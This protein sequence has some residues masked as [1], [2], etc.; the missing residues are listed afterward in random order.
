[1]ALS[2]RKSAAS[3]EKNTWVP[4]EKNVS[5]ITE[6]KKSTP[7]EKIPFAVTVKKILADTEIKNSVFTT[8]KSSAPTDRK[9]SQSEG[10]Q[11]INYYD[12]SQSIVSHLSKEEFKSSDTKLSQKLSS[13]GSLQ[14]RNLSEFLKKS[15]TD[16]ESLYVERSVCHVKIT[17]FNLIKQLGSGGFGSVILAELKQDKNLYAIKFIEK[18]IVLERKYFRYVNSEKRVLQSVNFPFIISLKYF[19]V[20]SKFLYFVMPF[21]PGGDFHKFLTKHPLVEKEAKFYIGQLVLALEYLHNLDVIHRDLKPQNVIIDALGYLKLAD[22]GQCIRCY[23]R[24]KTWTMTGTPEYMAPEILIGRGYD[25]SVDWWSLGVT[26][27]E[28]C[29]GKRPFS[30]DNKRKLYTLILSVKYSFPKHFSRS[31]KKFV[32]HL[33]VGEPSKRMANNDKKASEV[34]EHAW[35]RDTDWLALLNRSIQAPYL[36]ETKD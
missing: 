34:K 31:L 18:K 11:E 27:F 19:F 36:P 20:D 22:F 35:L 10:K 15:K 30:H 3:V 28:T 4:F 7:T 29:A 17:D 1:M 33:L 14:I 5:I 26:T 21:V 2:E 16:F 23:D 25:C 6:R 12:T 9:S 13:S 32:S 8:I 24:D